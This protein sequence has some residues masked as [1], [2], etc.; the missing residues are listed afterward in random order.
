MLQR[1]NC[2]SSGIVP[3][4]ISR[5]RPEV[6]TWYCWCIVV[7]TKIAGLFIK[8]TP[9]RQETASYFVLLT[10][11]LSRYKIKILFNFSKKRES[12][13]ISQATCNLE[14]LMSKVVEA[15]AEG[16]AVFTYGDFA[17]SHFCLPTNSDLHF[18]IQL[19]VQILQGHSAS[20]IVTIISLSS[21]A[22]VPYPYQRV[23][24]Q[25][26]SQLKTMASVLS[27]PVRM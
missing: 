15:V 6:A 25:K 26:E 17:A 18:F 3:G 8:V 27:H 20:V 7:N 5:S 13:L 11:W 22:A 4:E 10:L 21:P 24:K 14:G 1:S 16:M 19:P 9:R 12:N 2:S 23:Q